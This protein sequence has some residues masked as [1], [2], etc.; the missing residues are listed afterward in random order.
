MRPLL[1][2]RVIKTVCGRPIVIGFNSVGNKHLYSDTFG[3]AKGLNKEDL[4]NI[5]KALAK[6]TYIKSAPL[7]KPRKDGIS[8]FYYFKDSD[9][10]LY[11]NVAE[12]RRGKHVFRFL[13]AVTDRI[14]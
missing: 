12:M 9:K 13:Y 4:K 6:A 8:K 14:K 10:R 11:Y 2:K 3:R 5:D 1:K 7:S